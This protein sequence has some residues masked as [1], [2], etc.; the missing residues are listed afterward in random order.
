MF[1][2]PHPK[3]ANPSCTTAFDWL[4]GGKFFRFHRD[5]TQA[6]SKDGEEHPDNAHH[7]EHFWL[8]ERCCHVFTLYYEPGRG[9]V[10]RL[11][12]PEFPAAEE[13]E[14]LPVA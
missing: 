3:C 10:L 6:V 2:N 12:W 8:C 9:V 11:L 7:I 4:S 5:P 13:K 1:Q 14:A